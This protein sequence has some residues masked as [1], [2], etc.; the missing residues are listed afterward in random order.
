VDATG[1][2]RLWQVPP[3]GQAGTGRQLFRCKTPAVFRAAVS[4]DGGWLAVAS[5]SPGHRYVEVRSLRRGVGSKQL[6]TPA[7]H[8]PHG[9]AFD[10]KSSR[11]AIGV[12]VIAPGANFYKEIEG[13]VQVYDLSDLLPEPQ[14]KSIPVTYNPEAL[15]FHPDGRHLAVA[16]GDDHEVVLWDIKGAKKVSELVGPGGG[17]WAVALSPDAHYLA[18]KDRRNRDAKTPN[19][20]GAG[21]WGVFDLQQRDWAPPGAFTPTAPPESADGWKVRTSLPL[22]LQGDGLPPPEER[23]NSY[24]WFVESPEGKIFKL[25]L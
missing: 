4:P 16:G 21:D 22:N 6:P 12:R 17:L 24:L 13:R 25:P 2:V 11:L 15:A 14:G 7:A 9:L 5:E 3:P 1:E 19:D 18:F 8:R 10:H 20:R 23:Q